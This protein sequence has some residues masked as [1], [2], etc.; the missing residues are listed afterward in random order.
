MERTGT[1]KQRN[2]RDIPLENA[3]DL[4][5]G[6]SRRLNV[7][8][9]QD[10]DAEEDKPLK[11]S[12]PDRVDEPRRWQGGV[13]SSVTQSAHSQPSFTSQNFSFQVCMPKFQNNQQKLLY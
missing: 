2:T 4:V 3:Q 1:N 10:L 12:C 7:K 13:A 8:H 5:N 11:K 6:N 9:V